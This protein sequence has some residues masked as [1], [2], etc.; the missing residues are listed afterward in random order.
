MK[1]EITTGVSNS[2]SNAKARRK[3]FKDKLYE[4][5]KRQYIVENPHL[6]EWVSSNPGAARKV[7]SEKLRLFTTKDLVK[8]KKENDSKMARSDSRLCIK[9][10]QDN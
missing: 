5:N 2:R 8:L 6:A 10:G 7:I 9:R 3:E 4:F 1:G